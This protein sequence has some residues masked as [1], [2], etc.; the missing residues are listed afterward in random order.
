MTLQAIGMRAAGTPG[1]RWLVWLL[2]LTMGI[3]ACNVTA[4]DDREASYRSFDELADL[5]CDAMSYLDRLMLRYVARY[6]RLD[7]EGQEWLRERLGGSILLAWSWAEFVDP[8]QVDLRW[9]DE[10]W[11]GELIGMICA[12]CPERADHTD[13]RSPTVPDPG[14][15]PRAASRAIEL[16][17]GRG[18]DPA[19]GSGAGRQRRARRQHH[20]RRCRAAERLTER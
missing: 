13:H 9:D 2:A 18:A 1:R 10:Q 7:G 17:R 4:G 19:R 6:E 8:R 11:R 20:D 5:S 16:R 14:G 3:S 15:H 12:R